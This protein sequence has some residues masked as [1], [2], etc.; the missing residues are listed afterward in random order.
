MTRSS[1]RSTVSTPAVP[2][3][4]EYE[5]EVA[6]VWHDGAFHSTLPSVP[7]DFP[8]E[9]PGG[10]AMPRSEAA[11]LRDRMLASSPDTMLEYALQH[12]PDADSAVPWEDSVLMSADG[13]RAKRPRRCPTLLHPHE[14]RRRSCT[15]CSWRKPT[16]A[17]GSTV[18]RIRS[19]TTASDSTNGLS[20]LA[21]QHDIA[22][23]DRGAFWRRVLEQESRRQP[24]ITSLHRH[25]ARSASR[26]RSRRPRR[27]RRREIV[28]SRPGARAQA[29]AGEV[30]E[31]APA[32]GVAR[33]IRKSPT[34]LPVDADAPDHP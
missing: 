21:W 8:A 17:R 14:Q 30:D 34:R 32:A 4:V 27:Q 6:A 28:H 2:S 13:E 15:T 18:W 23:W 29:S 10:F 19:T 7:E 25:V 33:I 20:N 26:C 3:S 31:Q 12:R 22:T 1:P 5:D 11:W 16:S 24:P 9:V